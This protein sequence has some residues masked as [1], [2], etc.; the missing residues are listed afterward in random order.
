MLSHSPLAVARIELKA[1]ELMLLYC[2]LE[3]ETI[4]D[5]QNLSVVT[6]VLTQLTTGASQSV[7]T[8]CLNARQRELAINGV[9][10]SVRMYSEDYPQ[11]IGSLKALLQKLKSSHL[12]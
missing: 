12:R 6:P 11:S 8:I 3:R 9:D 1:D 2:A 7:Q 5:E 4:T 10:L